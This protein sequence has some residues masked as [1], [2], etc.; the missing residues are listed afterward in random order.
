VPTALKLRAVAGR[1]RRAIVV[2]NGAESEPASRKDTALLARSP[3]LIIDGAIAAAAAV[4]ADEIVVYV[5]RTH[6]AAWQATSNAIAERRDRRGPALTLAAAATR[7][8]SGQETS[9]V[10]HL[11][12]GPGLPTTVPPRPFERGLRNRPTL[13]CN[14]ETLAHIALIAR[15]G[16]DWFRALGSRSQ[17]G[18]ALVTF[19][20]A[21]GRPGVYEIAFGS[22]LAELLWQAEGA[23][24]QPQALLVGGY[25]GT[26]LDGSCIDELMLGEDDPLLAGGSIGAGVLWVLGERSCGVFETAR[27]LDYLAAQSAGQ[28]GPCRHGLRAIA[29]SFDRVARGGEARGDRARLRRWASEVPGRGACGHPDGAARFLQ[30]A[31]EVFAA[32]LD[33][34]QGGRCT[35]ARGPAMPLPPGELLAA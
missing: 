6:A 17:P 16:P 4:G 3:H 23:T 30:T 27:I 31:L 14:V 18:T 8:V 5:K 32:E 13:I 2:A 12:G 15:H 19:G 33:N 21:V 9:V 7:Y 25:G 35:A 29:D 1:R 20:G 10:S 22:R 24:E 11:D 34:H 28:C 26:W